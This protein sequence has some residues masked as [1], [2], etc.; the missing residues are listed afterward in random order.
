K[1]RHKSTAEQIADSLSTAELLNRY[2]P[3]EIDSSVLVKDN[4]RIGIG[5]Y[6]NHSQIIEISGW[7]YRENS[8]NKN[9]II[10]TI[11]RSKDKIYELPTN[12]LDRSDIASYFKRKDI[13]NAGFISTV[14]RSQLEPG[15][16]QIGIAV[17]YKDSL[18]KWFN[19]IPDNHLLIRS[20]YKIEKLSSTH[21][22]QVQKNDIEY[23]IASVE[24]N[25]NKFLIDGW[26]FFKN[27]DSRNTKINL[28]LQDTTGITYRVN[29]DIVRRAD[30][31]SYFKNPLLDYSGFA[32]IILKDKLPP[33]VYTLGIETICCNGRSSFGMG[34]KKI[35]INAP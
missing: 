21:S 3:I 13:F 16:Y 24:E 29:T 11:L 20:N 19:Y 7:A 27:A 35:I 8:N 25:E 23:N 18:K 34:D 17:M 5:H 31:S 26:A 6:K 15:D 4:I 32:V 9:A 2:K 33:G 14:S 10:K 28:I 30:V 12:Q 1:F 22:L